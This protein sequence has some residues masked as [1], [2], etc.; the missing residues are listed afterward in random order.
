MALK[1][2]QLCLMDR[3]NRADGSFTVT[4]WSDDQRRCAEF[5][6]GS[7]SEATY[8]RNAIREQAAKLRR[9]TDFDQ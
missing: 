8:L 7:E 5:L 3:S 6:C 9:V 2:I 1:N 4:V